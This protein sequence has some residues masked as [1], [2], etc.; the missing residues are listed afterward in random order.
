MNPGPL[1]NIRN[2]L[3]LSL[4]AILFSPFIYYENTK[5]SLLLYLP[6]YTFI[7][8]YHHHLHFYF[9]ITTSILVFICF[10]FFYLFCF[11]ES[12]AKLARTCD[13]LAG[14]QGSFFFLLHVGSILTYLNLC[15]FDHVLLQAIK[16]IF[17]RRCRGV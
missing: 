14:K 13:T 8:H 17:W 5:I 6:S 3:P 9:A 7:C 2:T 1:L 12:L 4:L 11:F 15:Y 10:A 16:H